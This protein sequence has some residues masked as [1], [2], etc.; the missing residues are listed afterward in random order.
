M[1][2]YILRRLLLTLPTLFAIL[3]TNFILVQLAPGGPVEYLLAK[4][5]G[6]AAPITSLTSANQ[7]EPSRYQA[8]QGMAPELIEELKIQFGFDKP[9]LERF[10]K[11]I[12]SYIRFDLGQSFYRDADVIDILLEKMPVSISLGL[13]STLLVYWIGI[14]LGIRKA[15]RQGS[16]FDIVSSFILVIAY[17]IPS[18]LMATFLVVM[19][20]G[21]NFLDWFP[22]RGLVSDQFALLSWPEKI[23]DY[24]WHMVLPVFALL[25]GSF[26]SLTFLT[27]NSFLEEINK[28]Y[29]MTARAKGL[30]ERAVLY[31][32]VFRNAM[33]LVVSGFPS[34][35]MGIFFTGALLIEVIF[36]LDGLGLLGFE[37]AFSRDYPVL[38]GTLYL[39]TLFGLLFNLIG[40]L[41]YSLIDPRIHFERHE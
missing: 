4:T 15:I 33:L 40:D 39:Y 24:L 27:K 2:T 37:S 9:L 28:H 32:H 10:W 6:E 41:T 35:F 30:K 18:F 36:S 23:L 13:L 20:S 8:S 3:L 14:P 21:G 19:F 29:V 16:H 25:I 5:S 1:K 7:D 38:F 12:L 34:A 11:M 26:A 17:A 31:Q 22:L